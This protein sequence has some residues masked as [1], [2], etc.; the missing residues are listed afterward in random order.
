MSQEQVI[1]NSCGVAAYG[2]LAEII[3]HGRDT[4]ILPVVYQE[5]AR[6]FGR[7]LVVRAFQMIVSPPYL[8]LNITRSLPQGRPRYL[9]PS[10]DICR[11]QSPWLKAGEYETSR[12]SKTARQQNQ[13]S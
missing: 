11:A 10:S 4:S 9:A 7:S 3:V 8:Y 5:V 12:N 13:K 1:L 2:N 6:N